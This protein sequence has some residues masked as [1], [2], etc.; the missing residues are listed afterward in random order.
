[1][2][3]GLVL[4]LGFLAA[5]A[6]PL[7]AFDIENMTDAEREAFGAE[8]REFLLSNPDVFL[9]VVQILEQ[10]RAEEAVAAEV[11]MVRAN[12][13]ALFDDGYSWVGGNPDGDVT[14]VEFLDYRCG[15]CKRAFPHVER[16]ISTDG[17]IKI[18][19]KEYP[20]LG[21][22]SIMGSRYAIATRNVE[23]DKAYKDVHDQMMA[24]RGE[25]TE[26]T[27]VRISDD[28]GLDH[29]EIVVEMENPEIDAIIQANYALA[30]ALEIQGTPTFVMG[31]RMVRGFVDL[32]QM[33]AIVADIR[34]NQG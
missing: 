6:A 17:N 2:F 1:M 12:A 9:E 33:R 13:E 16:L 30:N 3:R 24:L 31:E 26:E 27:L 32:D 4:G 11:D 23:G 10:R 7:A 18:I 34:E 25:L 28:L 15:F 22:A 14:I 19:V 20:I 5:T 8:V 21:D 29:E